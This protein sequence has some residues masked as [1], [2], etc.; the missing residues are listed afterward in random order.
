MNWSLNK[1]SSI[2]CQNRC[3]SKKQS[4]VHTHTHTHT[5]TKDCYQSGHSYTLMKSRKSKCQTSSHPFGLLRPTLL[6]WENKPNAQPR[7][8][9]A[10]L[11]SALFF[12]DLFTCPL[13]V[14]PPPPVWDSR[15]R[16]DA[17]FTGPPPGFGEGRMG[18]CSYPQGCSLP[19]ASGCQDRRDRT[20]A[21]CSQGLYKARA[22]PWG[23]PERCLQCLALCSPRWAGGMKD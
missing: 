3:F 8:F 9:T 1:V 17:E 5:H 4:R 10:C 20:W 23:A 2:L 15:F 19:W 22:G 13:H 7:H 18:A 21:L 14:T 16:I 6:L 11:V 12:T